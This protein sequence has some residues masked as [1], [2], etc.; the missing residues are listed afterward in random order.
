VR[1]IDAG[2]AARVRELCRRLRPI[3]GPRAD[4]IWQAYHVESEEGRLQI[5]DYLELMAARE[6]EG[7]LDQ[8]TVGLVPPSA[9]IAWGECELG[10][11]AYQ[12]RDMY[13]FGLRESEWTQHVGVFGRSGAGK[14]NLGFLIVEKLVQQ[15]KPVLILDWKRNYRDLLGRPG[16]E[17]M[18]VYT[19][20]RSIAP[21]AFN[22]LI[23]PPGTNPKTWL[24]KLIAV[25][26]HAY[27]LGN[28]VLYLLQETLDSV[29]EQFGVYAGHVERW[30]TFKD[31]LRMIKERRTSGRE[32]GW[33]S[34]A[35]RALASLTF[36]D[37]DA[38][39]N[40]D[41]GNMRALLERTVVLELDALTQSDKVFVIQ[42]LLLWIHHMRMIEPTREQF[43][44]AIVIEE[45]HHILT[46][47]RQSLVGGQ[48]V[49]EL[50]FREIREFGEA[51]VI[52]DQ[53]PSQISL[54]ALGNTYAT[55]C[56]NLK[57]RTDVNAMSQAMLLEDDEKNLLGA[58]PVGTAIVR[59]QGR[60]D[61]PFTIRVPEFPIRKGSIGDEAVLAH[62]LQLGLT[63]LRQSS[64]HTLGAD[65]DHVDSDSPPA[66][67]LTG[68]ETA[69][70]QELHKTAT[71]LESI[72]SARVREDTMLLMDVKKYPESGI[73]ER[74]HRLKW[75]VRMGQRVKQ[76]LVATGMILESLQRTRTGMKRVIRFTEKSIQFLAA[77]DLEESHA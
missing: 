20:G 23:P 66:S 30:P 57:H 11:I 27:L 72:N 47:E 26:A 24:K 48:S 71:P 25:V 51:I 68:D 18:A 4:Q 58:L 36:G 59:L 45:A 62:M 42:A 35:L 70:G 76:R 21:L 5:L 22:P 37:M 75:T 64:Q 8:N 32:A 44:H 2:K 46:G 56:F 52:L 14:T 33:L 29:Y 1:P 3:I 73:A 40:R 77:K 49:M 41:G 10:S 16:F 61:R 17:D 65:L 39:V 53:H 12:D 34:S 19:I 54:P 67:D 38:L 9:S 15:G 55:F 60:G 69:S 74:Y 43:K 7:Q 50:T 31:V 28:G 63:S 13:P 6:L